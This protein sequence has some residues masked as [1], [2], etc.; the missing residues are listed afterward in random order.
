MGGGS[1]M[2]QSLIDS[3]VVMDKARHRSSNK[4]FLMALVSSVII[5]S[6]EPVP[7]SNNPTLLLLQL[8]T[9]RRPS[10]EKEMLWIAPRVLSNDHRSF[11]VLVCHTL[12]MLSPDADAMNELSFEKTTIVTGAGCRMSVLCSAPVPISH[13]LIVLS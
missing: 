9:T 6:T 7:A 1:S 8:I 2:S 11:P 10:R 5:A 3:L 4:I 12:T 13:N